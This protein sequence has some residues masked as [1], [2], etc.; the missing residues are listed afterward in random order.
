VVSWTEQAINTSAARAREACAALLARLAMTETGSAK[1]LGAAA[2]ELFT[3]LPVT[4]SG[5]PQLQPWER[6]RITVS[7]DL[8]VDVLSSFSVI[9]ATLAE[10]AL[11][12]LLAWPATY[13]MDKILVPAALQLTGTETSRELPVVER[14]V[15]RYECICKRGLPKCWNRQ[16][17]GGGI[18]K[19]SALVRIAANYALFSNNPA[20]STW[21]F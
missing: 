1:D 18:V 9:D 15:I 14:C 5:F 11:D 4:R 10:N 16:R 13:D 7:I 19:S 20:Q 21:S 6:S 3:A 12:Y 8:V 2:R 17:I